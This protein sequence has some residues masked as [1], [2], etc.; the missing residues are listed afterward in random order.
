MDPFSHQAP[1]EDPMAERSEF[2][3][4]SVL[5][6]NRALGVILAV[7]VVLG[8]VMMVTGQQARRDQ[9]RAVRAEM[10]ATERLWHA[11]LAQ[12]RA[13]ILS[14]QSGHREAALTAVRTAAQIRP[15]VELR[16]EALAAMG[17]RDLVKEKEWTLLPHSYGSQCDPDLK[18]YLARYQPTV[19]SLYRLEDNSHVRDFPMPF[20]IREGGNVGD[21]QFSATGKFLVIRYNDGPLT[22]WETETGIMRQII[23]P[24]KSVRGFSWPPTFSADD[25]LMSMSMTG[26][27]GVQV[28]YDTEKGEVRRLPKLPPELQWSDS[29]GNTVAVS[30]QGDVVAWR[31]GPEITLLDAVTGAPRLTVKASSVVQSMRWDWRGRFLSF[32]SAAFDV[33][34]LEVA[35]GR[36]VQMGGSAIHPWVLR[37]SPDGSLLL[38]AGSD[39]MTRLWD[40]KTARLLSEVSG[41]LSMDFCR[42]GQRIAASVT[43]RTVSVWRVQQPTAVSY[44]QG[45]AEDQATVWQ[46][47]L[48]ADGRWLVW[49]SPTWT[50]P[51]GYEVFDLEHQ[52]AAFVPTPGK[53][54]VGLHPVKPLLWT[55]GAQGLRFHPLPM[56]GGLAPEALAQVCGTVPMPAGF[57][58]WTA[59][60]S[61]DGRFVAVAG[62]L[63]KAYVIDTVEPGKPVV[64]DGVLRVYSDVSGPASGTGSGAFAFSPDARWVVYGRGT[65]GSTPN[66]WD[67]HT[68]KGVAQLPLATEHLTFSPDGRWLA[69]VGPGLGRLW[70]TGSWQSVWEKKRPGLN[71]HPGAAAFTADGSLLAWTQD[72]D[73][74]ELVEPATGLVQANFPAESLGLVAGLRFSSD[75]EKLFAGGSEGKMMITNVKE[76]RHQLAELGLDWPLPLTALSA[77]R[78]ATGFSSRLPGWAAVLLGLVPVLLAAG[79]GIMV[80]HRQRGL[81]REFIET[82]EIAARRT[83]ELAAER[84]VSELKSRFVTTVSHE[85]RTP[86]GITMSAVELLQHYDDRLPPEQKVALLADIQSS[87]KNMA[88]LMEQVLVLGR[89]DA[90]KL[91]FKAN[92]IDLD[93]LARKLADESHSATHRKCLIQWTAENDLSGAVADESI[94]RH[95]FTNLLSNAVK[96]SP[97]GSQ[98]SFRARREGRY[99]IFSVRD[100]GIGI[101]EKDVPHLFEAFHRGANVGEIPGTG[102]GLV[103]TKRCVDLH[104]GS[105]HVETKEGTGTVF[106]VKI[107]AW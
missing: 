61:A 100:S 44:Y 32:N 56:A 95:I 50:N 37:F 46:N 40:A 7:V 6:A 75:G 86:L 90:G 45:T 63:G 59:S 104:G 22:L 94:L 20:F 96:Y 107:P 93:L 34:I 33:F 1:P 48:S 68:G 4:R 26:D 78:G 67:A 77:P 24:L 66:V 15:S 39:G 16:N 12:A 102:L 18:Y 49:A 25:R 3:R 43:G 2:I 19:L 81:T 85:F 57:T 53:V 58:P 84:E 83:Q 8:A 103:I 36:V 74:L 76:L 99:V 60:F 21:F 72:V 69:S 65:S 106:V 38:G 92:P 9:A 35:T 30:P 88:D 54:C 98:V 17:L 97:R 31:H 55:A 28:L 62:S 79:L 80:L 82:T 89:V 14:T 5:R 91:A 87:T 105:I 13:E 41:M 52:G 73:R 101:L 11:S 42:D 27:D 29:G 71:A 64:L 47:D 70:A 51:L 10:E 23:A